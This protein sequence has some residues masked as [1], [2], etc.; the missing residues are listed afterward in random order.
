[1]T[2]WMAVFFIFALARL[3]ITR[4]EMGRD[5]LDDLKAVFLEGSAGFDNIHDSVRKLEQRRELDRAFDLDGLDVHV[6]PV[7]ERLGDGRVLGR[8]DRGL[9]AAVNVLALLGGEGEAA[10]AEAEIYHFIEAAALFH[11]RCPCRRRPCRTR[12]ARRR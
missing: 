11:D 10:L 9:I 6:L 1:M 7:E 4:A 5:V 2:F 8:D 12:R 3:T